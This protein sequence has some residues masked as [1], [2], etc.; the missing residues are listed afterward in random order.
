M[1]ALGQSLRMLDQP[2]NK[3][4]VFVLGALL[5]CSCI[6]FFVRGPV[7][8]VHNS[9]DFAVFYAASRAWLVGENPYEAA[10]LR[11]IFRDASGEDKQLTESL[12]PPVTFP[13]LVPFAVL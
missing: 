8:G 4:R 9:S 1:T 11:A 2:L 10:T 5:I 13:I 6:Y 3:S 12:N 7:R